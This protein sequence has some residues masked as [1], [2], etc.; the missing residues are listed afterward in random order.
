MAEK[1]PTRPGLAEAFAK[2]SEHPE[3]EIRR[4]L[5]AYPDPNNPNTEME[6]LFRVALD[7]MVGDGGGAYTK[8]D[9]HISGEMMRILGEVTRARR[10]NARYIGHLLTRASTPAFLG[11]FLALLTGS[12]TVS[13]EVSKAESALERNAG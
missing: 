11:A 2:D 6:A 10:F 13:R 7:A 9:L 3:T 4:M 1:V 12:N 5:A 8:D